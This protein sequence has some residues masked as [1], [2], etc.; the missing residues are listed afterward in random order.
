[1]MSQRG[2]RLE[3]GARTIR[4]QKMEKEVSLFFLARRVAK[5]RRRTMAEKERNVGYS[6]SDLWTLKS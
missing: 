2:S 4:N 5:R 3:V 6:K 1:M